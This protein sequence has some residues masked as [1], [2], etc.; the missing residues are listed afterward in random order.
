MLEDI[1]AHWRL[2][3]AL[4]RVSS[5]ERVVALSQRRKII[6]SWVRRVRTVGM[7]CKS[8]GWDRRFKF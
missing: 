4:S 5:R 7:L 1:A 8:Y 3:G 2:H 6:L